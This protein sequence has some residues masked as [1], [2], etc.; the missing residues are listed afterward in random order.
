MATVGIKGLNV[1]IAYMPIKT[2]AKSYFL[3]AR[4]AVYAAARCQS[5]CLSVTIRCCAKTARPIVDW[6]DD[7]IRRTDL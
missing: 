3:P 1:I 7:G 4:C 2:D 6:T 5:V